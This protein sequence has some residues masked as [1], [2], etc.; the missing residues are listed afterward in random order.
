VNG[1]KYSIDVHAP[2][3]FFRSFNGTSEAPE[4]VRT[5]YEQQGGRPSGNI[6]LHIKN[7]G[8]TPVQIAVKDHSYGLAPVTKQ[9]AANATEEVVMWS[10]KSHGWYDVSVSVGNDEARYAGRVETGATSITDPAMGGV[11]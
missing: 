6:V 2:N 4:M 9:L 11:A 10:G 3:G 7:S 8:K 1:G 5:A